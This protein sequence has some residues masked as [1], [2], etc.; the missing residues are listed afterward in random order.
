MNEDILRE[1]IEE[2]EKERE[3]LKKLSFTYKLY[4]LPAYF[5]FRIRLNSK[6]RKA[7]YNMVVEDEKEKITK[8]I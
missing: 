1:K 3:Y 6:L 2:L 7:K 4:W 5:I 8:R